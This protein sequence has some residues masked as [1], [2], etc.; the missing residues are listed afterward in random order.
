M[1]CTNCG[2]NPANTYRRREE[3]R[4][5]SVCLCPAC[6]EKLYPEEGEGDFFT[7]FLGNTGS[8]KS[9][10]CPNCGLSLGEFRRTGLLG[11]AKCYKAFRAEL[12][13][14]VRYIQWEVKHEG[15]IP[16]DDAEQKY[17]RV[18]ALLR[19]RDFLAIELERAKQGGDYS[20]AQRI[21]S[22]LGQ[23]TKR[24]SESEEV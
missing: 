20:A 13:P 18:C 1:L 2:K 16:S 17:D 21:Q 22:Q 10:V 19:E 9:K 23:V 12:I 3:G 24:L 4:E 14:T 15:K 8:K 11:C 6:Y 7:Q 5:I